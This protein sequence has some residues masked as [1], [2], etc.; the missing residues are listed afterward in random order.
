ML[1]LTKLGDACNIKHV[2]L[3]C[4]SDGNV[5]HSFVQLMTGKEGENQNQF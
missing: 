2:F 5:A 1:H 4:S 3:A